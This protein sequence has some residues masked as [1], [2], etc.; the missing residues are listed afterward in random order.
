MF[1]FV[2]FYLLL[3]GIFMALYLHTKKKDFI[4]ECFL[5]IVYNLKLSV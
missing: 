2:N 4:R 5:S 3:T 1:A